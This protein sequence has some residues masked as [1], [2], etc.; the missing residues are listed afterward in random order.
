MDF[1]IVE[2]QFCCTSLD[3]SNGEIQTGFKNWDFSLEKSISACA[4]TR[5]WITQ[6]CGYLHAYMDFSDGEICI[7]GTSL[8]LSI[9]E[10]QAV[11]QNTDFSIAEIHIFSTSSDFSNGEIQTGF[12]NLDFFIGEIHICMHTCTYLDNLNM[13]INVCINGFP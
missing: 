10:L 9:G 12:K 8:D 1:S 2:I 7:F 5:F 3:F 4:H 13:C 6:I 11:T